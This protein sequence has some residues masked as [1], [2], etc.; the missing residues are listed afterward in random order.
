M[1]STK[2][3]L[4]LDDL[5]KLPIVRPIEA[6]SRWV[7]WQHSE[8]ATLLAA[9]LR[10]NRFQVGDGQFALQRAGMNCVGKMS[11]TD[12]TTGNEYLV[13]MLNCNDCRRP[14][15]VYLAWPESVVWQR[16]ILTRHTLRADLIQAL[17]NGATMIRHAMDSESTS[18]LALQDWVPSRVERLL[19]LIRLG[20]GGALLWKHVGQLAHLYWDEKQ[21]T[22]G[23]DFA[24]T[25][26]CLLRAGPLL[27]QMDRQYEFTQLLLSSF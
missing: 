6:G 14:L 2:K 9:Q 21:T 7:G 20:I 4:G 19:I 22:I 27:R 3:Y 25:C 10:A 24:A 17:A 11:L 5:Q 13:G 23:Y 1:F 8:V 18:L 15:A 26:S 12:E 16:F